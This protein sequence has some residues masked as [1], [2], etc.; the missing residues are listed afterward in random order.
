MGRTKEIVDIL[1]SE[2][3]RLL[4]DETCKSNVPPDFRKG[5]IDRISAS[6]LH[7]LDS[8]EHI[9][10]IWYI[11]NKQQLQEASSEKQMVIAPSCTRQ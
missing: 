8:D 10:Y 9:R 2:T 5:D 11:V 1:S 6:V 7:V 4:R 3:K